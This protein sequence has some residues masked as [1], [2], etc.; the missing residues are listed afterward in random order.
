MVSNSYSRDSYDGQKESDLF[1]EA[2]D[3]LKEK[4]NNIL[5]IG[6]QCGLATKER[7]QKELAALGV[8]DEAIKPTWRMDPRQ[9]FSDMVLVIKDGRQSHIYHVHKADLTTGE[10]KSGLL[11]KLIGNSRSSGDSRQRKNVLEVTVDLYSAQFI[12]FLLDYIYDD[13]LDLN[14][15]IAPALR[16]LANQF[17]VRILY[18]LV[19]SFIQQD[20]SEETVSTYLEQADLVHDS[21]LT[22][23]AMII[24]VQS[25]D[26]IPNKEIGKIPP[27]VLQQMVSDKDLNAPTPERLCQRI[28]TYMRSRVRDIDDESF[29]FLTHANILPKISPGE[30][31]W[32][33]SYGLANFPGVMN[34][35]GDGGYEASLKYRCILAASKNWKRSLISPIKADI[36]HKQ[37]GTNSTSGH[38]GFKK[39]RLFSDSFNVDNN[40]RAYLELP[41][42]V[43]V[44]IL[45]FALFEADSGLQ[46]IDVSGGIYQRQG[47]TEVI[48]VGARDRSKSI[49][50]SFDEQETNTR[51]L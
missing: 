10:R 43:K 5:G 15:T 13:K 51:W 22:D 8:E 16:R 9:S 11:V 37:E 17:D 45:Q 19:S 36:K 47:R 41:D 40:G 4:M 30:A 3:F 35:E 18:S 2:E 44:E 1:K 49:R 33:L 14:A 25:F 21:E 46:H 24:A 6:Y 28:A 12:P 20:L 39:N 50:D 32:F 23:V 27:Q 29:F 26:L 31:L 34:D 42:D 7:A 48:D 38:F